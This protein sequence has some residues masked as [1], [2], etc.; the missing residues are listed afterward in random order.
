MTE[1]WLILGGSSGLARA[2]A[3]EAASRGH[4]V[5]L[6]GRDMDDLGRSAADLR[7]R[8]A[9]AAEAV[10]FDADDSGSH[11]AFVSDMAERVEGP[12]TLVLAF[13]L[14]TPQTEA[15]REPAQALAMID[16]GYRGAVSILLRFIPF[17][18]AKR[19]GRVVVIGSVAGDRGRKSNFVYG[20]VKAALATF[21][22]GLRARLLAAGIPVTLIKPGFLDTAMTWPMKGGPLMADPASAAKAIVAAAEKG[23]YVAYVPFVWWGIMQIIKWIPT[24]IMK[25]L[26]F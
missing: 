12:L 18:E 25:R 2:I 24:G 9:V 16:A 26:S 22:E 4:A 14:M 13:A 1:T 10:A 20:S 17:Y 7:A 11:A 5:L 21:T 3:R 15:E 19:T 8:F 6:A 23:R